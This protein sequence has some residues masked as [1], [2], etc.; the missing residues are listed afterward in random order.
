MLELNITDLRKKALIKFS[1][2]PE[3]HVFGVH[4]LTAGAELELSELSRKANRLILRLEKLE[5]SEKLDERELSSINKEI[6]LI[7]QD[8]M[9]VKASV[10]DDGGDGSLSIALIKELTE[11]EVAKIVEAV[12]AGE[13]I[14]DGEAS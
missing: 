3:G 11:S 7:E 9:R 5:G 13:N 1:V 12:Q 2:K 6:E 4:R 14:T 10:F 8:R